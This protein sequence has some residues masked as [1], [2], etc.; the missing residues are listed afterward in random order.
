MKEFL[1]LGDWGQE[2]GD[3][4]PFFE[5][6]WIKRL[7]NLHYDDI[8][9]LGDNFY[10]NGVSNENDKQWETKLAR[11]FPLKKPKYVVLGN[12]DYISSPAAQ[13]S[14]TYLSKNYNWNMPHIFHDKYY[15]D[16]SCHVFFVD[17]QI[18]SPMY[19]TA[20][21]TA[22]NAS[23]S[24]IQNFYRMVDKLEN[25][26]KRWIESALKSTSAKWKIVIG[27]YPLLSCGFHEISTEVQ[28]KLYPL[29]KK[30]KVDLY[31][32]GHDH[33]SQILEKD[34]I[35]FVVS[36]GLAYFN[37]PKAEKN[38]KFVGTEKSLIKISVSINTIE[39]LYVTSEKEY[40][41]YTITKN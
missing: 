3:Q 24:C 33:N 10:P 27:H 37:Q 15:S 17:T 8:F 4:A 28:S 11:Y 25:L 38:A 21:L 35:H 2:L 39:F 18:M 12:H 40:S 20:M 32:S 1:L 13:V 22:C 29:L 36:G 19:T 6:K 14:F 41:V 9:L 23:P 34:G 7:K 31:A 26:Q 5:E 16:I 30:N